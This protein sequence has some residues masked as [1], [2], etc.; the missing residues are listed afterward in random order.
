MAAPVGELHVLPHP[1]SGGWTLESEDT[2]PA[3]PW[4]ATL[5]EAE[6][7]ARRSAGARRIFL[8]DRYYRVRAL[9]FTRSA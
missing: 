9:R 4:F 8:H 7:A 3:S 5:R 6:L 2:T 1:A